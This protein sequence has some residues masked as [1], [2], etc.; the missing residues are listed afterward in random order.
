MYHDIS[1]DLGYFE[2]FNFRDQCAIEKILTAEDVVNWD[3]D[4]DG[5]AEFWP[6]GSNVFVQALTDEN[7]TGSNLREIDRIFLE[8]DEEEHLLVKAVYLYQCES[9]ALTDITRDR[10]ED[11]RPFVY[12]PGYFS[13][14]K[15]EAAWDL[16]ENLYPEA[17]EFTQK[18]HTPGLSFDE[19]N[20]LN[21]CSI[22]EVP[23]S[24]DHHGYILVELL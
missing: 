22:Y 14:L 19:E 24:S 3:H 6:E 21:E 12:G 9:V 5:E 18:H 2:G 17:C 11:V 10:V 7:C 20:F 1:A 15:K 13:D 23:T 16:F 8:L 4:E